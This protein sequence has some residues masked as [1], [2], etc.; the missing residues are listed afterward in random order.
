MDILYNKNYV[1]ESSDFMIYKVNLKSN[2]S[3]RDKIIKLFEG[4]D[5][6][7]ILSCIQGHMGDI[8]VDN[9][10]NPTCVQALVGDFVFYAGD[11]ESKDVE[12]LL[13][14]IPKDILVI[15]QNEKWQKR[16]EELNVN[17]REKFNRYSFEKDVNNLDINKIKEFLNILPKDYE[18]KR[19][20]EEIAESKSFNELS[21]D[22]IGQ[23]ESVEDFINRG[24]GYVII[25]NGRVVSGASSY[26]IYDGGIEIEVDTHID[27]RRK[28]LAT[29]VSAALI[30]ECLEKGIYPSWDAANLNS[31][32]LAKKLGYILDKPYDTYYINNYKSKESTI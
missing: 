10:E 20:D 9:F 24:I 18:L 32:S 25:H 22:F 23:F 28:G 14:N 19:V 21:E 17:T 13:Y 1:K 11:S 6:T 29:I 3:L 7:L 8:W 12:Q 5:D 4:M 2:I 30:K 27:Y 15:A 31:V 26:S 16:I